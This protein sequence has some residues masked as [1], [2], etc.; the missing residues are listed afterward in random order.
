VDSNGTYNN[1]E[2]IHMAVLYLRIDQLILFPW[3][4]FLYSLTALCDHSFPKPYRIQR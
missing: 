4:C 2:L 1:V 3:R